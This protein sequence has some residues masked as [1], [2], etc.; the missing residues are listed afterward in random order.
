[1]KRVQTAEEVESVDTCSDQ[2]TRR[3]DDGEQWLR[4][5]GMVSSG[6]L[7]GT[8]C[9]SRPDLKNAHGEAI[10]RADRHHSCSNTQGPSQ[11]CLLW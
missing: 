11:G 1:M 2:G 3:E 8:G 7:E 5:N 10:L 4:K 9:L 6:T